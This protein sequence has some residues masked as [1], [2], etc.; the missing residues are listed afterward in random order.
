MGFLSAFVDAFKRGWTASGGNRAERDGGAHM[1]PNTRYLIYPATLLRFEDIAQGGHAD[2]RALVY[3]MLH[4]GARETGV[5]A[6][7]EL[8]A[9]DFGKNRAAYNALLN[10]G[11]AKEPEAYEE[12]ME[13]F[14]REDMANA[15]RARGLSTRGK[16][17][18][19]AER[20]M[21]S[22]YKID[23]R[24]YKTRWLKL[25][26]QGK[27]A[28]KEHWGDRQAAVEAAIGALERGDYYGAISAYQAFDRKWGFEHTSGKEHT[29]FAHYDIPHSRFEFLARY[30]MRELKNTEDFK[31]TLRACLIA[32]LMRGCQSRGE[33]AGDFENVCHEIIVCPRVIELFGL[34]D[35][36][37]E[38]R[39][40]KSAMAANVNENARYTLEYYIAHL[41]Y[42][43]RRSAEQHAGWD[44]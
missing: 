37:A 17:R 40:I 3:T 29:I 35:S 2:R 10:T 6:E 27:D 44:G 22:G 12:A 11:L 24:K 21:N 36:D 20:L 8:S 16:K 28:L 7:T 19:L 26:E 4:I 5:F 13:I 31:R 18:E 43:S 25:T 15:L 34:D 33:L 38:Q 23:R 41:E 1:V 39:N 14:T 42:L 9:L 32:G 30:Q